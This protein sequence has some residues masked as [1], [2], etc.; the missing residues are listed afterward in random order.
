M[1]LTA[2]LI[3]KPQLVAE[4]V[5]VKVTALVRGQ[6]ALVVL[7]VVA[8]EQQ[9]Q[10]DLLV[11]L[12]LLDKEM[13]VELVSILVVFILAAAVAAVKAVLVQMRL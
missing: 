1:E 3:H 4:V 6:A 12:E 10:M 8:Q 2:H 11:A 9:V 5:L 7:V 13:P